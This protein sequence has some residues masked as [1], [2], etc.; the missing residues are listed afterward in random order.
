M[1]NAPEN[2]LKNSASPYLRSAAHPPVDWHEWGDEAFQKAGAQ[3]VELFAARQHFNYTDRSE[4]FVSLV[5][6]ADRIITE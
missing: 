5:E 4:V 3:G 1:S 6:W 2:R